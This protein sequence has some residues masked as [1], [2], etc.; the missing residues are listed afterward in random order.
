[1]TREI[2]ILL[3]FTSYILLG[4]L[5]CLIGLSNVFASTYNAT[6]FT[7]QLYDNYGPSLNAVTTDFT[8]NRYQGIIPSMIANSSGAAWG[9]SS[10]VTLVA[11][12]TYALT[13]EISGPYAG[14][15]VLSTYNRIGVG[16]NLNNAKT[17]YQNNSS[18]KEIYSKVQDNGYTIQFA[19]TPTI[20]A[21]YIVFPFSTNLSGDLQQF[22]LENIVIDDL[23]SE[24]LTEEQISNSLN[25]QTNEINT[26][27]QNSTNTI[28]GAL[29]DTENSINSN[30]DNMQGSLNEQLG[31]RCNNLFENELKNSITHRGVTFT[32]IFKNGL[33]D[34]YNVSGVTTSYNSYAVIGY[35]DIPAG[36][37]ITVPRITGLFLQLYDPSS[38]LVIEQFNGSKTINTSYNNIEF[39]IFVDTDF[40]G[41]TSKFWVQVNEGSGTTYCP[42]GSYNS[43]LDETNNQLGDLNNN[44]TNDNIDNNNVSNAFNQ[45][46]EFVDEN[47]TI[48]SLLTLPVTLFTAILNGM[49]NSCSPFNLGSL[50]GE[51][52]ILPCINIGSYLG[53]GL[54]TMIDIIISG[55]AIYFISQKFIKVFNNFSSL[56]EGDVIDD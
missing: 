52:L 5:I 13:A 2:K 40:N 36:V 54:W 41:S 48:S 17:S 22:Y 15:L 27:I 31:D 28:T 55:F 3:N 46:E 9:V 19:F 32:P 44:I 26:S 47:A 16:T 4:V 11:N 43:K 10:P 42:Y 7:A 6:Q 39:N 25:A 23:G 56:K 37:T 1:M 14:K 24:T 8:N 35:Y 51:D 29:G 33:L 12:H 34:Y 21:S 45:F 50:Y 53:S 30:I 49:Q 18:V 38:G 20:N